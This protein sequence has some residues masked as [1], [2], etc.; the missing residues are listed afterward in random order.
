MTTLKNIRKKDIWNL[1]DNEIKEN[2]DEKIVSTHKS[3]QKTEKTSKNN[4]EV[5]LNRAARRAL[6]KQKQ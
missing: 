2:M 4:K 3:N 6:A 5:Q 1:F